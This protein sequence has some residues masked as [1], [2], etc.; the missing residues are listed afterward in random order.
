MQGK[1]LEQQ[2]STRRQRESDRRNGPDDVTHRG[3]HGQLL[4]QRQWF[5]AGRDIGEAQ[6]LR[7]SQMYQPLI[8][9]PHSYLHM[10]FVCY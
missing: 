10:N 8:C 1:H 7:M 5:L 2:V 9:G 3:W 6:E 4:C